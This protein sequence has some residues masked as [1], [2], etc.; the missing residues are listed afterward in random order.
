MNKKFLSLWVV[1]PI[2]T[3]AAP[4]RVNLIG[5]HIDYNGGHVLPCAISLYIKAA[6]SFN[7]EKKINL[8][9]EDMKG[10]ISVDLSNTQYDKSYSW[11]SYPIGVI[12]ILREMGYKVDKGLNMLFSSE[13]PLG[14]G[15]SSS[16]AILVLTTYVLNDLFDL[17]LSNLEIAKIAIKVE[18][19]YCGLSCGIMDQS[20]IALAQK[21]KCLYLDCASFEYEYKNAVL[22]KTKIMILNTKYERKLTDSKYN[23]RVSECQ[24]A[25][26]IIKTKYG[27]DNLCELDPKDLPDIGILLNDDLLYKRVK[28]CVREEARVKAFV[29]ALDEKDYSLCG[30]I[31]NESHFSLRDDYEVSGTNLDVITE[32]ARNNPYVYGARMTG[33]GFGGCAVALV[34]EEHAYQVKDEVLTKYKER[35]GYDAEVYLIDTSDG[36]KVL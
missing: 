20:A 2:K 21:D 16:A 6:V 1:D 29:T 9:S 17:G 18:R 27:V 8:V 19:E 23:E 15:L 13:I 31:L 25:L 22:E 5:E 24:K 7:E 36:P 30:K 28:H 32:I 14:S 33:A 3:Y 35:F 10:Q 26:S 4:A 34:D 12:H 11:A